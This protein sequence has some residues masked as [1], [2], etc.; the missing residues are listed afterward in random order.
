[1]RVVAATNRDLA[2]M[3]ADG[4]FREDLF[5]RLQVVSFAIPPLRERREDIPPLA[6][7]MLAEINVNYGRACRLEADAVALLAAEAWPGNVRELR[8]F[9]EQLVILSRVDRLGAAEVRAR[10]AQR[11]RPGGRGK[12]AEP[13]AGA[14]LPATPTS[15]AAG[16]SRFATVWWRFHK[17][18]GDAGAAYLRPL[19]ELERLDASKALPAGVE[20]RIG[21]DAE[22]AELVLPTD[23]VSRLHARIT[24]DGDELAIEDAESRNG[25]FVDGQPLEPRA[26][27]RLGPGATLRLGKEWVGRV[28]E[29]ADEPAA[30]NELCRAIAAHATGALAAQSVDVK[31]FERLLAAR[32][33][34]EGLVVVDGAIR[35][36]EP[37]RPE[38]VPAAA[39]TAEAV[40]RA[41]DAAKGNKR[42]AARL[43]GISHQTLYAKMKTFGL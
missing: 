27:R 42:E 40:K 19:A 6:T 17:T 23:E 7:Q 38:P 43:L 22:R 30:T 39:L 26:R 41:L 31:A 13:R 16:K 20:L 3:V 2:G 28:V 4:R 32:E 29:L 35:V 11:S 10:L 15:P 12:P 36:A 18:S 34:A 9:L 25:T 14:T 33:R 1:M 37:E 5:F 8:H 24:A 21:R